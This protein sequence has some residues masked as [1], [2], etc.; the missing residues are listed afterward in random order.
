MDRITAI[1]IGTRS[2]VG[3]T[4]EK[5]KENYK[6]IASAVEE[7]KERAMYDGQ[8]HDIPLVAEVVQNIKQS[9]EKILGERIEEVAVAA[10][11]RSLKTAK[12]KGCFQLE[13]RE[14]TLEDILGLEMQAVQMAQQNLQQENAL[15]AEYYCVGYSITN[16]FLDGSRM[17]NLLGQMGEKMEVEVI[18][19]F[20][21]RVVIDSL[22][23]VL[24]RAG[25]KMRSLTLEPIAAAEMAIP[26]N[27][28]QLNLA[29]I[30]I[31][32]GTSDIAITSDGSVKAYA[33][34]PVA[35]DEITEK[36]AQV[37]LLD[38]QTAEKVKRGLS[39]KTIRFHDVLGNAHTVPTD[40]VKEVID[41]TVDD[42]AKQ[43]ANALLEV[44]GRAPQAVICVGGGSLTPGL[45][46]KIAAHLELPANRIGVKGKEI[47]KGIKGKINNLSV[48]QMITPLG[49][50]ISGL[51]NLGFRFMEVGVNQRPVRLAT[52]QKSTVADALIAAGINLKYLYGKPGKALA[53]EINGQLT[54]LR[55]HKG[56]PAQIFLNDRPCKLEDN[57]TKGDQIKF[58]PAVDGKDRIATLKEVVNLN[59]LR[60]LVN[61]QEIHVKPQVK[62]NG[63]AADADFLLEDNC[64]IEYHTVNRLG[65]I[66]TLLGYKHEEIAVL[67]VNGENADMS[68]L[69]QEGDVLEVKTGR[70]TDPARANF[71]IFLNGQN[72]EFEWPKKTPPIL[73]DLFAL[74][75]FDLMAQ[76]EKG[77]LVMKVN[78][79]EA[80]FTTA[81]KYEDDVELHWK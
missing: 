3:I 66:L 14:I 20:L 52:Y 38:F 4:M 62:V 11:G 39:K 15:D 55:G 75:D 10:A 77:T 57:I 58:I 16:Y 8:I 41:D 5:E 30:D 35:G 12:G 37:F 49:I 32:A 54:F 13:L 24:K 2:V 48:P 22:F 17:V 29:L 72:M 21:P 79:E 27:M 80:G 45:I 19:T 63:R 50:A 6:I 67:K 64:K 59:P 70:N 7:H 69:L 81:L 68:T 26:S 25:L 28:R 51:K 71:K 78:G 61:D 44:N 31:G 33:M 43:I 65:E 76:K 56:T 53:V 47:L 18:A 1:D 60:I 9:L 23:A 34:V 42:L 46:A 73:S 74:L 40:K 36:I